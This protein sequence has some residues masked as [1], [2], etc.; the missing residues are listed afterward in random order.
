M[1]ISIAELFQ[2]RV[3]MRLLHLVGQFLAPPRWLQGV[4]TS[5]FRFL[6]G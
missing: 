6:D 1:S 5:D 3:S 2:V 4:L